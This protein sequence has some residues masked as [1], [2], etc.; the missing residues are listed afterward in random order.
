MSL[1]VFFQAILRLL[2][3]NALGAL[4]LAEVVSLPVLGGIA[5]LAAGSWWVENIRA[6]VPDFRRLWEVCTIAFL[7]YA[8][9]D[10]LVLADSFI[11]AVIHLLLFLLVYKL[12]NAQSHRDYLHLFVLTFLALV[13]ASTLTAHFGLLLVFS[14]D[15]IL[16]IWS[17]ILFHLKRETEIHRPERARDLLGAPGLIAPSFL[18]SGLGM[19]FLALVLT[20]GVFFVIPRV[21]RTFLSLRGPLGT[22][23]TGFTDRVDLGMYGAIQTDPTVVM[24]V[25]FPDDPGALTRF[26]DLRW[27]GLAFDRFDGR[28]WSL[29]DP[30]RTPARQVR[31]GQYAVSPFAVGSPFV[32]AEIF[33]EPIG[34]DVLFAPPRLRAI[35]GR[36][37]GV[38]VD[39]AGGVT[40][41][42]PPTSRIRYLAVSQPERVRDEMLRRAGRPGDYPAEVRT[43]Y[44]QLPPLPARIRALADSLSVG[45]ETSIDAVR[46]VEAY[47]VEHLRYSLDLGRDTGLDPLE[48]FLFERKTGN[49]EYFAASLVVLLRT[50]GIPARV[51]NGFQRGEWNEVGQY[52]AVRQRDA[53]SWAEVYFPGAGWVTVDPSPRAAFEGQAFGASG[54]LAKYFDALRWRWNRYVVDYNVGDQAAVAI[55]LRQQ[56]LALRQGLGSAWDRWSFEAFHS[57]RRLWRRYGYLVAALVLLV[58]AAIILVRRAPLAGHGADW[59]R[60]ARPKRFPTVFY[61]RMLRVLQRRGCPRPSAVTA[62]EF[63][64]NLAGR[65]H[66]YRPAAELTALYE[67]V[68]FG[69]HSLTPAEEAR[70]AVLLRE[71]AAAPR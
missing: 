20:L 68:R 58:A 37:P 24:R 14:L 67:R 45:A 6:A 59:L 64:A 5:A 53:H 52:L 38:R 11:T 17:L 65:P 23:A 21:G 16:R 25:S 70:A 51:V 50:M 71:L 1:P 31:E 2:V 54:R 3:L 30:G 60:T 49:C 66:Y 48:D 10:L 56:S 34:T 29:A 32:S 39:G 19:A 35:Q 12:Y 15:L 18:V 33:L 63:L 28:T 44:L 62:R 22:Q 36:V 47:L 40:L 13:A 27:R 61:E 69:G 8:I 7:G 9:L 41:P 26:P 43:V 4:Y 46:A 42:V 55:R 57:A